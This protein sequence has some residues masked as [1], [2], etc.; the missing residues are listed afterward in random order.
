MLTAKQQRFFTNRNMGI[1]EAYI[2]FY[3]KNATTPLHIVDIINAN[4]ILAIKDRQLKL[5][6]QNLEDCN[7]IFKTKTQHGLTF[8]FTKLT[9]HAKYC[10]YRY[11]KCKKMHLTSFIKCIKSH[12]ALLYKYINKNNNYNKHKVFNKQEVVDNNVKGV[13]NSKHQIKLTKKLSFQMQKIKEIFSKHFPT[14]NTYIN[15]PLPQGFE[16]DKLIE[17]IKQSPFLNE[18]EYFGLNWCIKNY[19]AIISG[20]YKPYE[21]KENLRAS[22]NQEQTNNQRAYKSPEKF[23]ITYHGKTY[24]KDEFEQMLKTGIEKD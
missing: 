4:P 17:C 13:K 21:K 5:L 1:K 7:L 18:K 16:I 3:I 20:Y 8:K 24:T 23:T 10:T 11:V 22:Q 12:F 2:Y 9:K 6:L 19:T 15:T 14:R